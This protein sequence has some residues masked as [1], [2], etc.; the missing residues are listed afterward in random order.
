MPDLVAL[1]LAA[2]RESRKVEFKETFDPTS[3]GEWCEL[4]KDIVAIANTG[5]GIIVFGLDS[6]C[7]P[8]GGP[9]KSVLDIDP[10]DITNRVFRYTGFANFDIDI[11]EV[12]KAGSSLCAFL[13]AAAPTPLVF[14][15]PGTYDV[16]GGK[17]KT[18][19]G[20]GTIYFRHGS[21]SEPGTTEDLRVLISKNVDKFRKEWAKGIRKVVQAPLGSSIL[22][23][24]PGVRARALS[25]GNLRLSQEPGAIPV[26]LTRD[27]GQTGGILL[28]EEI[29]DGIFDEINNVVDANR[30]LARGQN[31]F[32]LGLGLYY[33][34]Y[35]ERQH[36]SQ[37]SNQASLLFHAAIEELYA[38]SLFWS[39][40]M[41]DADVAAV[42]ADLF[43]RPKHPHVLA[44][45]R[46]AMLLGDDFRSWLAGKWK[47]KWGRHP[48]PPAFFFTF[49]QL[50]NELKGADHRVVAARLS[51]KK[52]IQFSAAESLSV[53][54][55]LKS[56]DSTSALLS[57]I[58]MRVFEG[59]G[60]ERS[61]AKQLDY[62]AYGRLIQQ[63]SRKLADAIISTVGDRE[64][65]ELADAATSR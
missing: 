8:K 14:I 22:T 55:L 31:R 5:D 10:A 4:V 24:E 40:Q 39:I 3:P 49:E 59:H 19:F 16:G 21:K 36:V 37:T 15:R 51:P 28:R 13:I 30:A 20:V 18:A 1:A 25:S 61:L 35:A 50:R 11:R 17:Q 42:Y 60:E 43:L 45:V 54:D 12:S 26:V 63:R 44:L 52:T 48:Q 6:R 62:I 32:V 56:E 58:C 57:K 27:S 38:P 33:R 29:A 7:I 65:E 9:T 47:D 2:T 41:A 64:P 46:I 34:I 23:V 53:S